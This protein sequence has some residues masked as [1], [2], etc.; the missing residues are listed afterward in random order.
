MKRVVVPSPG[1][2][3][4]AEKQAVRGLLADDILHKIVHD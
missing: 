4:L 3:N 1:T 2:T